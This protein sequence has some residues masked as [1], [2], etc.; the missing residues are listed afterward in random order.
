MAWRS[1]GP[2]WSRGVSEPGAVLALT[3][4]AFTHQGALRPRNEDAIAVDDWVMS[5]PMAQPQ[6]LERIVEKATVCLVADGMGGHAAG[7]V[8][9]RFVAECLADRGPDA[10]DQAALAALLREV[11]LGLFGL[12]RERP[13]LAGMGTTVAGLHVAPAALHVFNIGD[14]RVYQIEDGLVQLSTDDTLGPKL[15]DGRT[16]AQATALLSQSLG[17]ALAPCEVTPHILRVPAVAGSYLICSDGLT[18]LV[19]PEAM[20]ACVGADDAATVTA[21]F[22]AAMAAGGRDNISIVLVDLRAA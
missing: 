22:D 7:D 5:Q 15:A 6:V 21:L 12:M 17:G 11:D 20:A 19:A 3:A 14:S 4:T 8:A 10:A 13:A 1:I 16:A 18:D 9:S 2:D